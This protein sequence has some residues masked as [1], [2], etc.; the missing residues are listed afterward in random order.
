MTELTYELIPDQCKVYPVMDDDFSTTEHAEVNE[1]PW[2]VHITAAGEIKLLIDPDGTEY[3][4]FEELKALGIES[5]KLV[6]EHHVEVD[7]YHLETPDVNDG[8]NDGRDF[9]EPYATEPEDRVYGI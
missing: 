5:F 7:D 4:S 9:D 2:E 6:A 8:I 3:T 1:Q